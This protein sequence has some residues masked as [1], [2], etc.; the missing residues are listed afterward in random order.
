MKLL[1][2]ISALIL[3]P[4]PALA[5]VDQIARAE[6]EHIKALMLAADKRYE[7]RFDSQ[8]KA[9]INALAAQKELSFTT[10]ADAKEAVNKAQQAT[11]KRFDSVNEFRAQLKDQQ[12]T[13][14]SRAEVEQ[15]MKAL[16]D[17]VALLQQRVDKTEGQ[18]TGAANLWALIVGA[19]G[20]LF[21]AV[22]LYLAFSRRGEMRRA[23]A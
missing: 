1:I 5:Q 13:F 23:Q 8:E 11:E 2:L 4:M 12:T 18:G 6:I 16:T 22:G 17:V 19:L 20:L 21:G 15:R 3:C 7:Q 9:V 14:M 10:A